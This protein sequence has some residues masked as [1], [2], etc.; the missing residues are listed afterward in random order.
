MLHLIDR[1]QLKQ[2]KHISIIPDHSEESG[3][4][5]NLGNDISGWVRLFLKAHVF[6][7]EP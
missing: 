4:P 5:G 1:S 6:N 2:A 7:S 3:D